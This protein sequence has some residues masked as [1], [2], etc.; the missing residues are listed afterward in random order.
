MEPAITLCAMTLRGASL[1]DRLAAAAKSGF[2]AVGFSLDQYRAA[3][4]DGWNDRSLRSLLDD[5]GLR[6]A[7]IEAPWDWADG[8]A[9]DEGDLLFH[10][11]EALEC[12][13]FNAVQ[14]TVHPYE[15]VVERFAAVCDRADAL[16][17]RVAL[18]FMPFSELRTLPEAWRVVRDA[19]APNGGL[20]LDSWHFVRS[21]A[22]AADLADVPA[23][24]VFSAQLNDASPAAGDDLREEARHRRLLP[25][26]GAESFVRMLDRHGVTARMSVEVWSDHLERLAP[27]EAARRAY[28]ATA[29]V[30]AAARP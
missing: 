30:L 28:D 11:L 6:V 19:G 5:H 29:R 13:Q 18:E 20:L 24:R 22:S 21:G 14:F 15:R 26:G 1:A 25:A 23:G 10:A 16:D 8:F 2:E 4:R 27:E 7:E 12:G 9:Q 3:L 17:V